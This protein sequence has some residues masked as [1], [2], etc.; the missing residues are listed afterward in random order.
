VSHDPARPFVVRTSAGV[1]RVLGTRF[2]LRSD[3]DSLRVAVV[4]G[5]VRL[6]GAGGTVDVDRGHVGRI[7]G[8]ARPSV[9]EVADV[10]ALLDLPPGV[11][12]FQDTPMGD[13][14]R[15]LSARFGRPVVLRDSS[16]ARRLV[17]A[18]F[19]AE[20][21]DVVV[22]TVCAVVG[23]RCVVGDTIFVAR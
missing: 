18:S 13:A 8:K 15:E 17:T 2:A 16:V 14:L 20:P 10:W 6:S 7:V 12:L 22:N 4:D 11:I 19:E 1:V 5:R 3:A 9:V 23:A 21:L